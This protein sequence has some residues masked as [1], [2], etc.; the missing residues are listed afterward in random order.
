MTRKQEPPAYLSIQA[1]AARYDLST[2]TVRR[3]VSEGRL[4]AY[5]IGHNI[6]LLRTD[7]EA[8]AQRIPTV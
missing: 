2:K 5:K 6:R 3:L 7:V 1:V 4:P 8:L